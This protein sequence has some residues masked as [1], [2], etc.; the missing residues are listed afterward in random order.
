[1]LIKVG[2]FIYLMDFLV[3]EIEKVAN[4]TS[5]IPIILGHLF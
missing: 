3:L 4:I 5:Q 1:M 2:D